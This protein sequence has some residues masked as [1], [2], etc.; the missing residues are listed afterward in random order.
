MEDLSSLQSVHPRQEPDGVGPDQPLQRR[1]WQGGAR[2]RAGVRGV[3]SDA[4]ITELRLEQ[5]EILSWPGFIPVPGAKIK[6]LKNLIKANF[7]ILIDLIHH[8]HW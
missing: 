7:Q 1:D 3:Q 5:R 6:F 8:Q 2:V 4:A